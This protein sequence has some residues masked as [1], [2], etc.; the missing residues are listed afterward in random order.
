LLNKW[1]ATTGDEGG[2]LGILDFDGVS[3]VTGSITIV[4]STGLE[5]A[6]ISSGSSYSVKANGSGS[7]TLMLTGS[8]G[9][10]TVQTDFVLN[11]VS[12][13]VAKGLQVLKVNG[14][15][16][17]TH[18]SAGAAI[19]TGLSGSATAANL[20]GTYSFLLNIWTLGTQQAILGT[21]SFDGVSK[22]TLTYTQQQGPGSTT[23]GTGSGTY[24]VNTDGSG[25]MILTLSNGNS[26]T[27]DF[28][29]N[30][31][32]GGVAKGFQTLETDS[33]SSSS[34]TGVAVHQ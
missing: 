33:S 20:K 3:V 22:V 15:T 6:T 19:A 14:S 4:N 23:K 10:Q 5:V 17:E 26:A 11:S 2:A 18:V 29:I 8:G 24:S 25:S 28:V 7:M 21:F 12:S 16:S 34:V 9:S 31:V 27:E 1:T 13:A 32:S 30:S